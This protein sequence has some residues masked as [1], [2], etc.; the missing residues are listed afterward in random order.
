MLLSKVR[1][2]IAHDLTNPMSYGREFDIV[3]KVEEMIEM[4]PKSQKSITGE[5]QPTKTTLKVTDTSGLLFDVIVP[6][7]LVP[8]GVKIDSVVRICKLGKSKEDRTLEAKGHTNI[9]VI[10]EWFKM[11]KKFHLKIQNESLDCTDIIL[12]YN[13]D[14][15]QQTNEFGVTDISYLVEQINEREFTASKLS[16]KVFDHYQ[17]L[18]L[19]QILYTQM[20]ETNEFIVP[21]LYKS[22]FFV[23]GF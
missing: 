15:Q 5:E 2:H 22:R 20:P 21:N 13:R 10:D 18:T 16:E 4:E 19:H 8:R 9:M 17:S 6:S 1:E 11:Y 23:L 12:G 3:V 14:K 7:K